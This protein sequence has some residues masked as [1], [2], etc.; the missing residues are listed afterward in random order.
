MR[1]ITQ[2]LRG[3]ARMLARH[4]GSTV[5]IV[6]L[7]ALGIGACTVVFSLFDA[8]FVRSLPVRQPG[9]LVRLVRPISKIGY[10]SAFPYA[11]YRALRRHG[12]S[13]VVF[14]QAAWTP[15]VVMGEPAPAEYVTIEAVTSEYFQVLGV[16]AL[17]GR[18][19][20]PADAH[21][22]SGMPP[23][24][25]SYDFWRKRFGGSPRAVTGRSILINKHYFVIVGVMPPD[26]NGTTVDTAP[27][28]WIPLQAFVSW[29]PGLTFE[30]RVQF[31]IDGR[32]KPGFEMPQAV[33]E[34]KTIFTPTLKAYRPNIA[35]YSPRAIQEMLRGGMTLQPA[36]RGVSIVRQS[37]GSA[38]KLLMLA[39]T[40]LLL[41][42]CSSIAG[43]L[44]AR[45][46]ARQQEL[47]VRLALGSTRGRLVRQSLSEGLLLAVLGAGG[48][49][50]IAQVAVPLIPRILPPTRTLDAT[51]API[52]MH[53]GL[54]GQVLW[55]VLAASVITTVLFTVSP[56]VAVSRSKV[57]SLL[58]AVRASSGVRGRQALIAFQIALCTFLLALAGLFVRTLRQLDRVNSGMDVTHIATFTGSLA[59]YKIGTAFLRTLTERVREIPGVI[60]CAVSDMG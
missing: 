35:D 55:F 42:V 38:L 31:E 21:Q 48:A 24:V 13:L 43:L 57:Q 59:G 32:L 5:L 50:L 51:L 2:D 44:L 47:A 11:Y 1:G 34:C 29:S 3:A 15:Q 25:L 8:V 60:S 10:R 49:L 16:P 20:I 41:I 9:R 46:A 37:F 7:L 28:V 19:L 54:S 12:K 58:R 17:Y 45:A 36:A 56:A 14:G 53:L 23:A 22:H 33:A 18:A 26:F 27:D 6:G 52:S 30:R 4:P 39:V 40:V